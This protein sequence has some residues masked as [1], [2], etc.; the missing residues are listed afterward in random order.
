MGAKLYQFAA[1]GLL[2][3]RARLLVINEKD[4]S[5]DIELPALLWA[6][7][8]AG[9]LISADWTV[10]CFSG[11]RNR[12]FDESDVIRL[13]GAQFSKD[14]LHKAIGGGPSVEEQ[15]M[16][17][18]GSERQD[19]PL[20][21]EMFRLVERAQ[22]RSLHDAARQLASQAKGLAEPETK[23]KRIY[24]LARKIRISRDQ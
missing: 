22:A 20:V 23:L 12:N 11:R 19:M 2:R 3:T 8:I 7:L 4:R 16:T 17:L 24:T 15:G 5:T 18:T 6:Q 21:E 10:G 9:G 1:D 14:D 13:V